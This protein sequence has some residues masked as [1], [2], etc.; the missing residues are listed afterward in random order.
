MKM[1]PTEAI[2][3]E[4]KQGRK[5]QRTDEREISEQMASLPA[6]AKHRAIAALEVSSVSQGRCCSCTV[7]SCT[8]RLRFFQLRGD[9][10]RDVDTVQSRL[11]VS[12]SYP[13]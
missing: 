13:L 10:M 4:T 6:T 5:E 12:L 2:F 9:G 3:L 11:W 1:R 8:L 7:F